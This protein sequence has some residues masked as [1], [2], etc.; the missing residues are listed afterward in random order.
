VRGLEPRALELESRLA[1]GAG[2]GGKRRK[3][4]VVEGFRVLTLLYRVD[5]L[6]AGAFQ[7]LVEMFRV[8]RAVAALYFWSKRLGLSEGIEL[9]LERAAAAELLP[10][11]V[12]RGFAG[13]PVQRG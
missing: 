13:L 5:E 12:R 7:R 1:R 2:Y 9:T 3:K 11:R 10:A 8:Y 6:P 4:G